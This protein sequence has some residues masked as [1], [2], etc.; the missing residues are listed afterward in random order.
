MVSA[1][2]TIEDGIVY[3]TLIVST[4]YAIYKSRKEYLEQYKKD[5]NKTKALGSAR[6]SFLTVTGIGMIFIMIILVG[7]S[8][9]YHTL[10][11]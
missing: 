7:Q 9:V 3:L 5:G 6:D 8:L 2:M 11:K 10:G 1:I 4:I